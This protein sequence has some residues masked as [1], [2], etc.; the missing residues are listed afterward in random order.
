MGFQ[1]LMGGWLVGV[2]FKTASETGGTAAVCESVTGP[3]AVPH[4]LRRRSRRGRR[5]RRRR[6]GSCRYVVILTLAA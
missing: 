4:R 2:V 1:S 3:V 5:S 6:G